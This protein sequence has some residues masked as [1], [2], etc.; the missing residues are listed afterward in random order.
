MVCRKNNMVKTSNMTHLKR[1]RH[2][3]TS[4]LSPFTCCPL[5]HNRT[6]NSQCKGDVLNLL[7]SR[8]RRIRAPQVTKRKKSHMKAKRA[9]RGKRI[10][11]MEVKKTI[12]FNQIDK[13]TTIVRVC[14]NV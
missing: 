6:I 3:D 12:L 8:R 5:A 2:P 7:I 9:L 11:T 10:L 1:A 13:T 14:N 4:I